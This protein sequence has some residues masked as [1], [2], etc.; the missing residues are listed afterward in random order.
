MKTKEL[1]RLLSDYAEIFD[2]NE[3]VIMG[4]H[5]TVDKNIQRL[6]I[7]GPTPRVV[8]QW[9][10]EY[11]AT[12]ISEREDK[13]KY[14][15]HTT[16]M[17]YRDDCNMYLY[18]IKQDVPYHYDGRLHLIDNPYRSFTQSEIDNFPPEIKGAVECGFLKKV[19]VEE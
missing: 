11:T 7:F 16:L 5:W 3:G 18:K 1:I 19:E 15:I 12:P 2:Q 10:A 14:L 6:R 17:N 8:S 13:K 9:L 4:M